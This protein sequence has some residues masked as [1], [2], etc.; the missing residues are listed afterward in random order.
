MSAI[1]DH[2][3][4]ILNLLRG[5]TTPAP[6]L[7]VYDGAVPDGATTPY[8]LVYLTSNRPPAGQGN[9]LDGT[10]KELTVRAICHCV[11]GDQVAAR[12]VAAR[13]EGALLDVRPVVPGRSCGLIRQ[14]SALDP[15]RDEGTG[16]LVMDMVSIYRLT[17]Q[18][19]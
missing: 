11:G 10:S 6:A 13:V 17:T 19:A 4:A 9:G 12:A 15:V 3:D 16:P 1:Q 7:V 8:V 5:V 18:P 14:E 2:A